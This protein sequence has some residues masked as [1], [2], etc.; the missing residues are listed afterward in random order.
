[1]VGQYELAKISQSTYKI[2]SPEEGRRSKK[3]TVEW[4]EQEVWKMELVQII[5]KKRSIEVLCKEEKTI[6]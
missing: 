6:E 4:Q 2:R 3:L 5:H 1:L